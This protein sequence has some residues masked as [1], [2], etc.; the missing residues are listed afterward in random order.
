M[1]HY[2]KREKINHNWFVWSVDHA[3]HSTTCFPEKKKSQN[4]QWETAQLQTHWETVIR[5]T[6][7]RLQF[8]PCCHA[9]RHSLDRCFSFWRNV[10]LPGAMRNTQI[11][12][13]A[14]DWNNP[15]SVLFRSKASND[16]RH[17]KLASEHNDYHF[18]SG[19]CFALLKQGWHWD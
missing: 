8:I 9:A 14:L 11:K 15:S 7:A 18:V 6:A 13:L 17:M 16:S 2:G 10:P 4:L 3:S 19:D 1:S 12:A 5:R